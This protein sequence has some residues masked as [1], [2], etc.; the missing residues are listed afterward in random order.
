MRTLKRKTPEVVPHILSMRAIFL[1]S[2][3][4]HVEVQRW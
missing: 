4:S 2:T 1:P 3:L